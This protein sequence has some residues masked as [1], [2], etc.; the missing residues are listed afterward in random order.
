MAGRE[1][2]SPARRCLAV[3]WDI[4]RAFGTSLAYVSYLSAMV[5]LG[6]LNVELVALAARHAHPLFAPLF[7][8]SGPGRVS[9][10][11][12]RRID[13]ANAQPPLGERPKLVALTAPS[14]PAASL[15]R[16]LDLA[17]ALEPA[18]LVHRSRFRLSL[19]DGISFP[20]PPRSA[21]LKSRDRERRRA[22]YV[23]LSGVRS[24]QRDHPSA[25]E[26]FNRRFAP[27]LLAEAR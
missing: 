3:E 8:D 19:D 18:P 12:K 16:R 10:I 14:E 7:E 27:A 20:T 26:V 2:A 17:E 25:A 22:A 9:L 23:A 4:L 6:L 24:G 11:E 21:S 13:E 5:G 1:Q 15:A